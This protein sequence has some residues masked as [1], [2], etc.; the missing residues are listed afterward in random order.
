MQVLSQDFADIES[1]NI[2]FPKQVSRLNLESE[3]ENATKLQV[4]IS[5][6]IGYLK[7]K[8]NWL[9]KFEYLL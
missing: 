5:V 2:Q 3:W 1:A 6:N 9:Y 4:T 8:N 7:S